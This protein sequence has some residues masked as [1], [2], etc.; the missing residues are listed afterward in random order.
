MKIIIQ[1]VKAASVT[2]EQKKNEI[3]S[4]ICV[5]LGIH[6]T[7]FTADADYI[8]NKILNTRIFDDEDGKAWGASVQSLGLEILLVSQFTL[9]G[10]LKGNKPDFHYAMKNGPSR[11]LFDYVVQ[12]IQTAMPGKVQVGFF[13]EDMLVDI[14]NDGPCT[15]IIESRDEARVEDQLQQMSKIGGVK[16]TKMYEKEKHLWIE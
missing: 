8:V 9:Y 11:R 10:Y 2:F 7:D 15:L 4:G 16:A 6:E 13:G 12:K 1:K 3:K 5:L 14:T